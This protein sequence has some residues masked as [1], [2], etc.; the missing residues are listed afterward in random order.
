MLA[1]SCISQVVL[2]FIP[3]SP[4]NGWNKDA[5]E[6]ASDIQIFGFECYKQKS[7]TIAGGE[8]GKSKASMV[9]V[10]RE[11]RDLQDL[12]CIDTGMVS[13][14]IRIQVWGYNIS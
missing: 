14:T 8:K 11:T 5:Q 3:W 13:S 7:P 4:F 10:H 2:L 1:L 9:A 6:N 12:S